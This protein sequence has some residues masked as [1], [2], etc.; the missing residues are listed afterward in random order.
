MSLFMLL[1][2]I[3]ILSL[4]R[5]AWGRSDSLAR[6]AVGMFGAILTVNLALLG[7]GMTSGYL[8]FWPFTTGLGLSVAQLA[9]AAVPALA[10]AP[11]SQVA[12]AVPWAWQ[13]AGA[14]ALGG[15]PGLMPNPNNASARM[16]PG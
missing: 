3:A 13:P 15:Q 9:R 14:V 2:L 5:A 7:V 4:A 6:L 1:A 12:R 10:R 16:K 11:T 8:M